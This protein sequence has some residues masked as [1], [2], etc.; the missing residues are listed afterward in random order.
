MYPFHPKMVKGPLGAGGVDWAFDCVGHTKLLEQA[1]SCSTGAA[2]PS[3]SAC[4]GFTDEVSFPAVNLVQVNRTIKGSRYGGSR[5]QHD[6]PLYAKWYQDGTLKLDELVTAGLP[7][8]RFLPGRGRHARRQTRPGRARV[9]MP[10][11]DWFHEAAAAVNNWGRW[12]EDDRI[13]TLNF[14]TPEVVQT[15]RRH[16]CGPD[17]ASRWPG[18]LSFAAEP[19]AGQHPGAHRAAHHDRDRRGHAGRPLAV[20]HQ[21]RRGDDGYAGR[22]PLGWSGPRAAMR[23]GSTTGS[24]LRRSPPSGATRARHP[25]RATRW[26]PEGVLLDVARTKGSSDSSRA[27]GHARRSRRGRGRRRPHG[28]F[29]RHR[30]GQD[31]P[32]AAI[33]VAVAPIVTPMR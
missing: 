33:C 3:K 12:G 22:D 29:R 32:D 18:P 30:V 31:R 14:I 5:P 28:R 19:A 13:G 16:A 11:P 21:R 24:P 7:V 8:G 26:S 6:I 15:P 27:T 9:L 4:P 23:V 20:L 1:S 2:P 10:L 17:A 25:P